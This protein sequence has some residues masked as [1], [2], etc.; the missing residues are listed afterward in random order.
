VLNGTKKKLLT[1]WI[2][3]KPRTTKSNVGT[4]LAV[5]K[6]RGISKSLVIKWKKERDRLQ[7]QLVLNK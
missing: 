4:F 1:V 6:E 3:S 2:K 5:A 7:E